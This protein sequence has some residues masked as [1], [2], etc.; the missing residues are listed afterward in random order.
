MSDP[1]VSPA[2]V[3]GQQ[4]VEAPAPGSPS[5]Q[6]GRSRAEATL[7]YLVEQL[8]DHPEEIRVEADHDATGARFRVQVGPDDMGRVIGRRGRTA[9]AIRTVVRVAGARDGVSATSVEFEDR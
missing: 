6:P 5:G 4:P 3:D 8:A 9:Q 1:S 2:S 7:R